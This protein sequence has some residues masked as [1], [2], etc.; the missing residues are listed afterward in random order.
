MEV[1]IALAVL[2]IALVPLF[3]MQGLTLSMNERSRFYS[4]APK[5]AQAR[6]AEVERKPFPEVTD[7]S[8]DFGTDYPGYTWTLS[9]EDLPTELISS[10]KYHLVRISVTVRQNDDSDYQLQTYRFLY[11]E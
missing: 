6:L 3:R 9:V 4:V 2:G 7:G 1:L 5:L 10:E 8:G 11:E